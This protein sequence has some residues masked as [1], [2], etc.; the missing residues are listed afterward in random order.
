M[1][2]NPNPFD[3]ISPFLEGTEYDPGYYEID[4]EQLHEGQTLEG[5]EEQGFG[6]GLW[7]DEATAEAYWGMSTEERFFQD[8]G[9]FFEVY[10]Y[11]LEEDLLA[12][13]ITDIADITSEAYRQ[14]YQLETGLASQGLITGEGS[15]VKNKYFSSVSG[16]I[17]NKR[18][19]T[20]AN[21]NSLRK[22]YTKGT[23][24]TYTTLLD[25]GVFAEPEIAQFDDYGNLEYDCQSGD[26]WAHGEGSFSENLC[27][28]MNAGVGGDWDIQDYDWWFGEGSIGGEAMDA[29]WWFGDESIWAEYIDPALEAVG[30]QILDTYVCTEL[31]KVGVVSSKE[32]KDMLKFKIKAAFTH[33]YEIYSYLST[34]KELVDKV[35]A[36]KIDWKKPKYKKMFITNVL[37][38][39]QQGKH[40]DAVRLYSDNVI[41]LS[42]EFKTN[43]IY[44]KK[45]FKTSFFDRVKAYTKMAFNS[46]NFRFIYSYLK[47]KL[48]V[49]NG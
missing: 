21:I 33:P 31:N 17:E 6:I 1:P 20:T 32:W 18:L 43:F 5:Y 22:D 8:Y 48:G 10:D 36:K 29:D 39:E 44:S 12:K 34:V 40:N 11:N 38:L 7:G 42:K 45:L 9:R 49:N 16:N 14:N 2:F 27:E 41:K 13:N 4:P 24:D 3:Q 28:W 19:E 30:E 37:K 15:R 23:M 25:M 46:Y 47:L 35:N 26:D